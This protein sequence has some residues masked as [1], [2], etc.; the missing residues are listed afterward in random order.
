MTRTEALDLSL[1]LIELSDTEKKEELLEILKCIKEEMPVYKWTKASAVDAVCQ[2]AAE[3]GKLPSVSNFREKNLPSHTVIKNLF[4]MT[5]K[6]FLNT[7]FKEYEK[8]ETKKTSIEF[9]KAEFIRIKPLSGKMY[10]LNKEKNTPA[11]Q[12]FAKKANTKRWKSLLEHCGLENPANLRQKKEDKKTVFF[13]KRSVDAEKALK[14][15]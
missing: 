15:L 13:V 14:L 12:F 7:Y 1:K 5:A 11:W 6:E 3:S 8:N 10:N 9:F 4:N 2:W